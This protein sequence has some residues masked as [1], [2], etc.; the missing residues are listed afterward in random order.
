MPEHGF[1]HPDVGYWQT[2]SDVPEEIRNTY[3]EGTIEVPIKPDAEHEWVDGVWVHVPPSPE[4]V[5]NAER[6]EWSISRRQGKIALGEE[7]WNKVLE[8][9]DD[10]EAPWSLR[11][12]IE[13]AIE[14]RRLSP[15]MDELIWAMDMTQE[16]VD[17]LFRLAMTL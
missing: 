3:P 9:L 13:E 14:W 10:P 11:V 8:I 2:N 1:Y 5:L 16:E 17:D 6:A 12:T 7:R 4:D 15:E